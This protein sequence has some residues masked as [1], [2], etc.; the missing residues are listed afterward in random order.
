M[1][2]IICFMLKES[3]I[4]LKESDIR[5]KR[6]LENIIT[7]FPF[8]F[9]RNTTSSRISALTDLTQNPSM[10]GRASEELISQRREKLVSKL[11]SEIPM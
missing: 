4:I 2:I 9:V 10:Y 6:V 11:I 3:D 1:F 7:I 5:I 8:I